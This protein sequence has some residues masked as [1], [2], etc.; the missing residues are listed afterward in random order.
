MS[1]FLF[2]LEWEK[3][4]PSI[5]QRLLLLHMYIPLGRLNEKMSN[6]GKVVVIG[7]GALGSLFAGALSRTAFHHSNFP[8]VT[9]LTR[10]AS[11]IRE[12]EICSPLWQEESS[13]FKLHSVCHADDIS[14]SVDLVLL[15]VKGPERLRE[16]ATQVVATTI[17]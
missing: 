2:N 16:A 9:L 12:V 1:S 5:I 11:G 17:V 13:N 8:Q 3:I 7:G 4:P 14:E 15:C 6:G 10:F